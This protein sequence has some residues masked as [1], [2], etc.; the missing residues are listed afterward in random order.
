MCHRRFYREA[1][2]RCGYEHATGDVRSVAI[3]AR[4]SR[5]KAAREIIAGFAVLAILPITVFIATPLIGIFKAIWLIG[6]PQLVAGATLMVGGGVRRL[7][8]TRLLDRATRPELPSARVI[9]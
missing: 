9:E 5:D 6:F 2:C 8:A 4:R 3:K 1:F 7:S